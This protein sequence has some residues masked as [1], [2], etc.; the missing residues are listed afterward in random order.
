MK[1][2]EINN[3][4]CFVGGNAS[5]NWQIL[6]NAKP[7]HLFFHLSSFSSCY[8]ISEVDG[9]IDLETIKNIAECCKSNTKYKNIPKVKVDYTLCSNVYKGEKVGEV[10]YKSNKKVNKIVV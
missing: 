9:L 10:Y 4:K 7:N 6:D 5:E 3:I 1:T 8:V 2:I